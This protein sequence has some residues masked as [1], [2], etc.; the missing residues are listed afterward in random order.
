MSSNSKLDKVKI[1]LAGDKLIKK[2]ASQYGPEVWLSD[3]FS[4]QHDLDPHTN[5]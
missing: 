5:I 1:G 3:S 4:D 2:K